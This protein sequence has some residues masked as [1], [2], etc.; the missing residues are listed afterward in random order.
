MATDKR[1]ST[2]Y[3]RQSHHDK[4]VQPSAWQNVA[5]LSNPPQCYILVRLRRMQFARL[6]ETK[7]SVMHLP[8]RIITTPAHSQEQSV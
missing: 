8:N 1:T 7:Q 2:T 3:H 4:S 6:A 5:L